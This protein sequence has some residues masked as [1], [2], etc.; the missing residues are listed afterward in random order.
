MNNEV[1][2]VY[3]KQACIG[4]GLNAAGGGHCDDCRTGFN[5]KGVR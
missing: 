4:I 1:H 2:V 3:D 5:L